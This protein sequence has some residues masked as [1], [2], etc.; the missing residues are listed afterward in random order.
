LPSSPLFQLS[1][2]FGIVSVHGAHTVVLYIALVNIFVPGTYGQLLASGVGVV[3]IL[4]F[5]PSGLGGLVFAARDAWLRRVAMRQGIFVPSLMGNYRVMEGEQARVTLAPKFASST[6]GT[7]TDDDDSSDRE[8]V[9]VR[10]RIPSAIGIRGESQQ[11]R[12][13]RWQG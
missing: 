13:W 12:G 9:P 10:Y 5:Y 1:V 8:T 6:V 11:A 3:T 2:F 4:L 7:A